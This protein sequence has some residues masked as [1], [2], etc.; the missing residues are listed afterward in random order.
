[1]AELTVEQFGNIT[2][3]RL[4]EMTVA[5]ILGQGHGEIDVTDTRNGIYGGEYSQIRMTTIDIDYSN[6]R[7]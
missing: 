6:I 4:E 2:A 3:G 5:E 7:E 1:M